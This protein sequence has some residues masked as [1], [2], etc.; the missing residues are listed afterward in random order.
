MKEA[1]IVIGLLAGV[2]LLAAIARRA[3]LPYAAVLVLGGLVLGLI[4][5]IPTVRLNP[6]LVLLGFL[7]PLVYASA[8][9][10]ASYDLRPSI[11]HIL[12]LATGLV[13][14]TVLVV[15]AA[16]RVVAGL[17]WVSAFVLGALAA[18]TDPVS[19]SAVMRHVG[20][21]ERIMAIL[22]GES[23]IN[24]GTGLAA[25]QVAVV[26]AGGGI[27]IGSG[28]LRFIAISVGG[29][30]VGLVVGW[31]LVHIRRRLDEPSLEIVLG[32]LAA[33]GSYVAAYAI[34]WSGVLAAVTAGLYAGRYAEDISSAG[35]EPFWDALT[36]VLESVLFLLI[37]LQLPSIVSG[38]RGS[39][40][41]GIA[42]GVVLVVVVFAV[43]A[44]WMGA[45]RVMPPAVG[46]TV[47]AVVER[48]PGAHR[49]AS[50]AG[51]PL[52]GR[53]LT[54][55]GFSGMRGALSLAGALSIPLVV[56]HHP[57]AARDQ[58]IFLVYIVVIGTLVLPSLT[59]ESLVR[60]LGLAGEDE[61]RRLDLDART[62]VVQA[63]LAR[64]DELAP[65][66]G[67][68]RD[69]IERL[70]AILELR[71]DRLDAQ[72]RRDGAGPGDDADG[73]DLETAVHRL[74]REVI[75]AERQALAELRDQREVP[76]QVL[77]GIQRD[78]DLDET[79]LN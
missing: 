33:F 58:V 15:A 3:G 8:F 7:P 61:L 19:A 76:A 5:G 73:A 1:E 49:L 24:D 51:E 52:S 4:P 35:T 40:G 41:T 54:V 29:A 66:A 71:M 25:F 44:A 13:L 70:R 26:A 50:A 68:P 43:R 47:A 48:L 63:G 16:G 20:A 78:I 28:V 36:F 12:T 17:P 31:T 6:Q 62:R 34:G 53:E 39:L 21:P 74:R 64:L 45:L 37:G 14:L 30:A 27:S 67:V 57:F 42:D 79:R 22:E 38:L 56:S 23:L 2:A 72:R 60:R 55:L 9:Q 46:R 32:M 65:E 18:P 69:T 75:S 11:V 10:A 59:L 77:A